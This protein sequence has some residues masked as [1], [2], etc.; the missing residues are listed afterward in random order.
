MDG[1]IHKS[2]ADNYTVV[3]FK[4]YDIS[5][6]SSVNIGEDEFSPDSLS[7]S[8][9]SSEIKKW[10]ALPEIPKANLKMFYQL[11]REYHRR[12][13]LSFSCLIFT[14]LGVAIG[15]VA[16]RRNEKSNGYVLSLAVIVIYWILFIVGDQSAKSG[17][18]PAYISLWITNIIFMLY[19]YRKWKLNSKL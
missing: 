10:K 14:M 16:N 8:D 15:S 9:L 18:I 13:A 4:T 1:E 12:W 17:K 7:T 3:N 11:R 6:S 19:T 2:Q 5:L